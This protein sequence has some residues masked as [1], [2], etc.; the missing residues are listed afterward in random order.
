MKDIVFV[1]D[2]D[3]ELRGALIG[4]LVKKG[5]EAVGFKKGRDALKAAELQKPAVALVDLLLDDMP[6]V[7]VMMDMKECSPHTQCVVL[8]GFASVASAVASINLGAFSYLQKPCD[9]EQILI[10]VRG[11]IQKSAAETAIAAHNRASLETDQM[12]WLPESERPISLPKLEPGDSIRIL[13]VEDDADSGPAMKTLLEK[14]KCMATLAPNAEQALAVFKPDS[15]DVIVTDIR[16]PGKSGIELLEYVRQTEADFPVILLTGYDSLD[17]AIQAVRLGAQ[18]YI[19]KPLDNI[20]DVVVPARNAVRNHRMMLRNRILERNLKSSEERWRS[21]VRNAPDIIA[22]ADAGGT[23]L[24]INR[25][26]SGKSTKEI[27]GTRI[28]EYMKPQYHEP[29]RTALRQVFEN[30]LTGSCEVEAIYGENNGGLW[31]EA[32]FGPITGDTGVIAATMIVA[33]VTQRKRASEALESS[34]HDLRALWS[35]YISLEEMERRR[36]AVD[37]HDQVGQTLTALGLNLTYLQSHLVPAPAKPVSE[38]LTDSTRLT[39]Q[40]SRYVTNVI[41]ELRPAALEE[42]GLFAALRA[43]ANQC[44]QRMGIALSMTGGE[45]EPRL[46]DNVEIALFRIVQEAVTNIAK[47]AK[48]TRVTI[49]LTGMNS[50]VCL[51]I[52]DD[53]VG[54]DVATLH[55]ST[56]RVGLGLITMR[57]RAEAIGAQFRMESGKGHGVKVMVEFDRKSL[58]GNK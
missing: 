12:M 37:L 54:F 2:D 43:Y 58:S 41:D 9:K 23:I 57:E 47:H 49:S 56:E 8:T 11:A 5:Y 36:L 50:T 45:I 21:L 13:L 48:A 7:A 39:E 18:D 55:R 35:R 19:L 30:G 32:H 25:T 27:A 34:H 52:T 33:D 38:R 4:I 16:L 42:W 14:R 28:Y 40:M 24:F 51:G 20:E 6:G 10:A 53:G 22:V 44:S 29:V 3:A 15:F 1:I 46:P 17:S 31:Y 26:V